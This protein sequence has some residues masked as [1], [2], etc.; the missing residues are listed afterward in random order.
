[1]IHGFIDGKSRKILFLQCKT[2]NRA[3]TVLQL[4]FE[5]MNNHGG[6]W[7]SR[8]RVDYGVE[9]VLICDAITEMHGGGRGSFIAG[10]S[11]RI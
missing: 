5:L 6:Y 4:F 1:M 9:N 3:S 2:N 7:P 11:T 10:S 8:I